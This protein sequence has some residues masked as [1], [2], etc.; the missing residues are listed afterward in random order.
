MTAPIENDTNLDSKSKTR[1]LYLAPYFWPEEIGSAP[2][3]SE[4]A[5]HLVS[6]GHEVNTLAFR[7]HYPRIEQFKNWGTGER[8]IEF[9]EG[10]QVER[11]PVGGRGT[12]G[13]ISRIRND[14]RYLT[15]AISLAIR[16]RYRD[17]DSI[18]AYVPSILTLFA[19]RALQVRSGA[20]ITAVVHD[21][22]SGLAD[23]LGITSNTT[24][25]WAMRLVERIGLSFA[26]DVVVLTDGMQQQLQEIGCSRPIEI[27][28]IWANVS[29]AKPINSKNPVR[30]MYSGN[31]G[32]KQNLDQLLPLLEHISS[33]NPSVEIVMRGNGSERLRIEAKTKE[34]GIGNIQFSDLTPAADFLKSLHSANL[35]LVPQALNVANYALP[36]KLISI[37]SAG[38]PFICIAERDSPLYQLAQ[39]SQAGICIEPANDDQLCKSVAELLVDIDRQQKMG[40]NGRAYAHRHMNRDLIFKKYEEIILRKA[41]S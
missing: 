22:E 34:L 41:N 6:V 12:G 11:V 19:A 31:F 15:R 20:S 39:E 5:K 36:S 16:G 32:K 4:L 33:T 8:D 21:I 28:P 17:S 23:S 40:E 30:I 26:D 38:R 13:F 25:L 9:H 10:I 18:V 7:P 29:E 14:L 24:M 1:V 37:M 35:H 27:L 2:Y 3:T